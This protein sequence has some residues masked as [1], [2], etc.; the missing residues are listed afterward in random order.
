MLS[1]N[2]IHIKVDGKRIDNSCILSYA[3]TFLVLKIPEGEHEITMYYIPSG[4]P[5][6]IFIALIFILYIC[7]YSILHRTKFPKIHREN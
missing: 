7:V 1:R 6:G 2:N 3:N 5:I 4:F